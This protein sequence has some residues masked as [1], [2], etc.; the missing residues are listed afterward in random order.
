MHACSLGHGPSPGVT[1]CRGHAVNAQCHA[2]QLRCFI[3]GMFSCD[4]PVRVYVKSLFN[5]NSAVV[6][7]IYSRLLLFNQP[8][9]CFLLLSLCQQGLCCGCLAAG[10]SGPYRLSAVPS[11][12]CHRSEALAPCSCRRGLPRPL[13][14]CSWFA[15]WILPYLEVFFNYFEASIIKVGPVAAC[16]LLRPLEAGGGTGGEVKLGCHSAGRLGTV[17]QTSEVW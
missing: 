6:V 16:S 13:C 10:L 4:W 7:N 11:P 9:S 8:L 3:T 15:G 14:L 2:P 1:W 17:F 12:G 5:R